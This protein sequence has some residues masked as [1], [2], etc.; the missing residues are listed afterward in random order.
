ML[1]SLPNDVTRCQG[2]GCPKRAACQ[3]YLTMPLDHA[4]DKERMMHTKRPYH[5]NLSDPNT[6]VCDYF[7][8]DK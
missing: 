7:M 3:R 8:D 1:T 2:Q 4:A 6:G 5:N